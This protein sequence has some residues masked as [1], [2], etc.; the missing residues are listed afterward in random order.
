MGDGRGEEERIKEEKEAFG[1]SKDRSFLCKFLKI[2]LL[3]LMLILL[4][5]WLIFIQKLKVLL[6]FKIDLDLIF[7]LIAIF[8]YMAFFTAI[9]H[10]LPFPSLPFLFFSFPKCQKEG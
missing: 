5:F 7:T 9:F 2:L 1:I 4:M 8:I 3:I 6:I 10:S